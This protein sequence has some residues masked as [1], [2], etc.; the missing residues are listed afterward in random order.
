MDR[1]II[2]LMIGLTEH[3]NEVN[4]GNVIKY[5]IFNYKYD[6]FGILGL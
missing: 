6:G 5:L 1:N 4:A 3:G 2:W